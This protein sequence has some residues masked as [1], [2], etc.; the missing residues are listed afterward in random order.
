MHGPALEVGCHF[1][2]RWMFVCIVCSCISVLC[3]CVYSTDPAGLM[4]IMKV[5]KITSEENYAKLWMTLMTEHKKLS[6][7]FRKSWWKKKNRRCLS[8]WLIIYP[9]IHTFPSFVSMHSVLLAIFYLL[10]FLLIGYIVIALVYFWATQNYW[11]WAVYK[12]HK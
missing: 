11:G 5:T 1:S 10:F 9:F 4:M 12:F 2:E 7:P 6:G 3:M 8:T